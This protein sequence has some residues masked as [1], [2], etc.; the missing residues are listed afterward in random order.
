MQ[1][2]LDSEAFK[3]KKFFFLRGHMRSGTNWVGNLLNLHPQICCT[4]E[5]YFDFMKSELD[6][7][8]GTSYSLLNRTKVRE[9]AVR[10]FEELVKACILRGAQYDKTKVA[11]WYGDRTP[12]PVEPILIQGAPHFLVIRDG[13]DIMVSWA[14]HLLRI[15][16]PESPLQGYPSMLKKREKFENDGEFFKKN[17]EQ[18]LDDENW[19]RDVARVWNMRMRLGNES[20]KRSRKGEIDAPI[21]VVRYEELHENTDSERCKMYRFLSLD[22]GK[23]MPMD[24]LTNP[25]FEKEDTSSHNRKGAVGDWRNYFTEQ[26]CLWFREEAG[27]PLID[28]GYEKDM[29]WKGL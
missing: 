17:P 23:A 12:R 28:L 8:T 5:Y 9:T 25:G 1:V 29:N 15:D 3:D 10:S 21:H 22:P 16:I 26:T 2:D 4:G 7:I 14:Y 19:V 20:L 27:R 11:L 18:L 24:D 6:R 13:R